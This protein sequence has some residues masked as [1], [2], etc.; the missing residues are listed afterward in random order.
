MLVALRRLRV[1][2][3]RQQ[4]IYVRGHASFTVLCALAR[5]RP[6]H[7]IRARIAPGRGGRYPCGACDLG[8]GA[9][10][11]PDDY[12][13]SIGYQ[14]TCPAMVQLNLKQT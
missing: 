8:D 5:V 3:N 13:W 11:W 9:E 2:S 10:L 7:G 14:Q 1:W 4:R 12:F 6:P